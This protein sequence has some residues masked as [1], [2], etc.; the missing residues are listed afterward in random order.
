MLH[1]RRWTGDPISAS[2]CAVVLLGLLLLTDW[3]ADTLSLGRAALWSA[4]AV[5]L[6]SCSAPDASAPARAG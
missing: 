3:S 1:D 6:F 4:L 5:L 2:R